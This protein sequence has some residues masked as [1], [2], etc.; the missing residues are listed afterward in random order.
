VGVIWELLGCG[1][2]ANIGGSLPLGIFDKWQNHFSLFGI[3]P[4]VIRDFFFP[5]FLYFIL[6]SFFF[7]TKGGGNISYQVKESLFFL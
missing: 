2:V 6:F 3:Y 5:F 1:Q 4:L 7:S